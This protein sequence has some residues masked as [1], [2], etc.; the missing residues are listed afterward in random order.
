MAVDSPNTYRASHADAPSIVKRHARI[1]GF[2]AGTRRP[3]R[4]I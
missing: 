4:Y 3:M 1:R 2:S